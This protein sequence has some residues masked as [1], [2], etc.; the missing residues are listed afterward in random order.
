MM[1]GHIFNVLYND[2][3]IPVDALARA[4]QYAENVHWG[5]GS[6][7]LDQMGCGVGGLVAM[8]FANPRSPVV[9]KVPFDFAASGY[10]L[11]LVNAGGS[12]AD[13]TSEYSAMPS[14]MMAVAAVFGR[15]VLRGVSEE[16]LAAN[17]VKIRERCG[18]RAFLRAVHFV[19]ENIRVDEQVAALKR[20]DFDA[21]LRLITD[22]GNSSWKLLQNVYVSRDNAGATAGEQP[23]AAKQQPLGA[24]LAL[25]EM[26]IRRNAAGRSDNYAACR[27]HGGGFAGVIQVFL[28]KDLVSAYTVW[29][30][31]ALGPDE[32]GRPRVFDMAIRPVGVIEVA[33]PEP[34]FISIRQI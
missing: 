20:A 26:F 3:N 8:D 27:V 14:E 4:G 25:T 18:D 7:L 22:S 31:N 9:E 17:A 21:F 12:H 15:E 11:I 32:N 34:S 24:A 13:L 6:G 23:A 28:P 29:M 1:M 33:A 19:E 30:D 5:K 2:G 16:D 10:R